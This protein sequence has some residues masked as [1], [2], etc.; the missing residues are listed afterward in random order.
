MNIFQRIKLSIDERRINRLRGDLLMI[1]KTEFEYN[2]F[3]L[4]MPKSLVD[5]ESDNLNLIENIVWASGN[6]GSIREFYVNKAGKFE[7]TYD[8]RKSYFATTCPNNMRYIHSGLP[9][10]ISESMSALVFGNGY[11]IEGRCFKDE[12][13]T[14]ID[15]EKSKLVTE[16]IRQLLEELDIDEKL[17]QSGT[18]ESITG[19][20]SWKMSIDWTLSH[21]PI[22]EVVD[23]RYYNVNLQRGKVGNI[24][25]RSYYEKIVNDEKIYYILE[26]TYGHDVNGNVVVTNDLYLHRAG[27]MIPVPLTAI[28]ETELLEPE[29]KTGFNGSMAFHKKNKEYSGILNNYPYGASDY[30]SKDN[31]DGLDEIVTQIVNEIRDNK[32]LRFW[33]ERYIDRSGNGN[34]KNINKYITNYV[35][36]RGSDDQNATPVK[37]V[38]FQD[39]TEQHIRKYKTL[40]ELACSDCKISPIT[41]G[42]SGDIGLASSDETL[43]ERSAISRET[44]NKKKLL[45][46]SYLEKVLPEIMKLAKYM[47]T[48]NNYPNN[49]TSL[50]WKK[51]LNDIDIDA[52]DFVVDITPYDVKSI[53]DKIALWSQAKASGLTSTENAIMQI[54]GDTKTKDEIDLEVNRIKIE[55]GLDL[56]NPDLLSFDNK[57]NNE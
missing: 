22:L 37:E 38:Q 11:K 39:K 40:V 5:A 56:D 36:Y 25:Y 35:T 49:S 7:D 57:D 32:T 16:A 1:Q 33:D 14:E 15:V 9:K 12:A 3:K 26:E 8:N 4:G 30:S 41:L 31:F 19:D 44:A 24:Q 6:G 13:R 45:W 21:M 17:L 29:I 54:Y 53:E 50:A 51:L 48:L 28:P 43:K 46:T 20:V 55:T 2:P 27:K 10:L 23:R 52:I 47:T 34:F 18:T 42:L